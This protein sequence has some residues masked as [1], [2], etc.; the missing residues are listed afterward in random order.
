MLRTIP[1]TFVV[2][3][4]VAACGGQSPSATATPGQGTTPTQPPAAATNAPPTSPPVVGGEGTSVVHVVIASGPDAGTYDETGIKSDCN[5]SSTGS[6]ATFVD[7]S[8]P[9]GVT[10]L[11]F[12]SAVGGASLTAGF[13]FQVLLGAI[14][15]SQTVLEIQTLDPAVARGS[16]TATLQDNGATIK[17]TISGMTEDGIGVEATVECGPVDRR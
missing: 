6:G 1:V 4:V 7:L 14:S 9:E 16:G 10:S 8:A 2:L 3:A 13:Y 15:A 11:I 5:T 17:W 12:S